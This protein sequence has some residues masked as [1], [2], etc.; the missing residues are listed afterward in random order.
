MSDWSELC[1]L[2]ADDLVAEVAELQLPEGRV[3]TNAS[4]DPELLIAAVS[5]RHLAVFPILGED[6]VPLATGAHSLRKGI[7]VLIWEGADTE[8][9]R[10]MQN[11]AAT[12]AFLDLHNAVRARFYVTA[13]QFLG[14]MSL[15]WY[16]GVEFPT[17]PGPTRWMR[18][19]VRA[20]TEIAF[21]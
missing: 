8:S 20:D 9:S 7:A 6:V 12:D 10:R 21:T 18:I 5:E 19:T 16:G 3:H 4:W 15:L 1:G 2:I 11:E 13:H 17:V 14:G